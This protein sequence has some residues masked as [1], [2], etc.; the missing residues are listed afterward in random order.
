MTSDSRKRSDGSGSRRPPRRYPRSVLAKPFPMLPVHLIAFITTAA[1]ENLVA[2]PLARRVVI[3]SREIALHSS[4]VVKVTVDC[5]GGVCADARGI[6]VAA[7]DV[8]R[9]VLAVLAPVRPAL[10]L[11][12]IGI[13]AAWLSEHRRELV[14]Y[15]AND[16]WTPRQVALLEQTVGGLRDLELLTRAY[17]DGVM[18][19]DDY[20]EVSAE[21][22]LAGG[23][24]VAARSQAQKA[25]MVPWTVIRDGQESRTYDAAIGAAIAS[26]LPSEAVNRD[27]LLGRQFATQL[28]GLLAAKHRSELDRIGAEDRVGADLGPVRQVGSIREMQVGCVVSIDL[29]FCPSWIATLQP[30]GFPANVILELAFPVRDGHVRGLEHIQEA[31]SGARRAMAVPWLARYLRDHPATL[32][33]V[34]F[35][36]TSSMSPQAQESFLSDLRRAGAAAAADA[37]RA[38]LPRVAFLEIS[39]IGPLGLD[40]DDLQNTRPLG[41]WEDR[42]SSWLLLP[43]SRMILWMYH[44]DAVLSFGR[45]RRRDAPSGVKDTSFAW[46]DPTTMIV[47]PDGSP[48]EL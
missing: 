5:T 6:P 48:H 22:A 8:N 47:D 27:R 16:A 38:L 25:F 33:Y 13:N 21:I 32:A 44:G 36:E 9:L 28:G 23:R 1:T 41:R 26:L 43:D 10:E 35:V 12:G 30:N 40:R 24:A 46:L 4:S 11:D 2:S 20:P 37:L 14:T 15:E 42:W 34:H 7:S 31:I 29:G 18:W 19:T 39:E 3:E 45:V 17:Y